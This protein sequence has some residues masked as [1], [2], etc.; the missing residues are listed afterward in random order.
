MATQSGLSAS[1]KSRHGTRVHTALS[2]SL[3]VNCLIGSVILLSSEVVYYLA[4]QNT[5]EYE[6]CYNRP[7]FR[8][9]SFR[10]LMIPMIIIA[11]RSE[12]ILNL[13]ASVT[14]LVSSAHPQLQVLRIATRFRHALPPNNDATRPAT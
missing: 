11:N 3:V 5:R 6:K 8:S 10:L 14:P 4:N 2:Y 7:V 1:G 9:A 12:Q 13:S